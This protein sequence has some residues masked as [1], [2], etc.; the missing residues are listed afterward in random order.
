MKIF[1]LMLDEPKRRAKPPFPEADHAVVEGS[2]PR[3]SATPFAVAGTGKRPSQD[4]RAW[5]ADAVCLDCRA[6]VGTLRVETNTLFG[7][8]EDQA[9]LQGRCRVY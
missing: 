2:C 3:C 5:E 7:V 6:S 8:R 1:L 4:D 9:V